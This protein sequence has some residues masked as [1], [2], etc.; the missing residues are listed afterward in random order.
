MAGV[1]GRLNSRADFHR[2]LDEALAFVRSGRAGPEADPGRKVVEAQLDAMQGWTHG[3]RD[4]R[5]A[6]RGRITLGIFAVREFSDTG[7]PDIEDWRQKLLALYAFFHGWPT[8]HE[9]ATST[10]SD[11]LALW[12]K[13]EENDAA[14]KLENTVNE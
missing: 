8:D 3:G 1:Y 13:A 14:A 2:V 7:D 5:P 11:A 9:A 10:D 4:P 6:E 12:D